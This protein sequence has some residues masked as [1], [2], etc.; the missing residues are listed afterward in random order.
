MIQEYCVTDELMG[1]VTSSKC[2]YGL[3]L[4]YTVGPVLIA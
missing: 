2:K 3:S 4:W 1:G